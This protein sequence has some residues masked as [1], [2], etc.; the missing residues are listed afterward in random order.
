MSMTCPPDWQDKSMLILSTPGPGASGVTA[1]MVVTQAVP[2]TDLPTDP[3]A[4]LNAM[5]DRQG[6]R[7]PRFA[8]FR[9]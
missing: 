3:Q 9:C 6:A 4:R 7:I 5:L 2:P 1:N 8:I